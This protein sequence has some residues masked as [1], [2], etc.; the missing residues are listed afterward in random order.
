MAASP[1]VAIVCDFLEENW[2]S[3]DLVANMLF[4][5]LT[6][7]H[8]HEFAFECIRPSFKRRFMRVPRMRNRRGAYNA[9][10]VLNRFFDY[11]RVIRRR[12]IDFDLFHVVDHSYAH[13]VQNV[14]Q[15]KAV[16][17]CHDLD[18]FSPLLNPVY[19]PRAWL[20]AAMARRIVS[21]LRMAAI[22]A[23]VS[24]AT[25]DDLLR[26]GIL[27]PERLTIVPNGT[28][29]DFSPCPNP[30]AN[31][32][33][34]LLL[35]PKIADAPELLHVG[36]SVARKRIDILLHVF[37]AFRH[38]FPRARLIRVGGEPS[39]NH[40]KLAAEL[41][42]RESITFL[43]FIQSAVLAAVYRRVLALV[44]TSEAEGFCLPIAEAMA[45]GTPAIASDLPALREVGG[46]AVCYVPRADVS[47]YVAALETISRQGLGWPRSATCAAGLKQAARFSWT[48]HATSMCAIYRQLL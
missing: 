10:R 26:G 44:I 42:I 21:G 33:A 24:G 13:L 41:G 20:M 17:T 23:C 27:M 37:A 3:M 6:N 38:R 7:G 25:R 28:H 48:D 29:P 34:N 15:G 18:A 46:E 39:A 32:E 45:C 2:P 19:T 9:D 8:S 40:E 11:P 22:V 16:V 31:N 12:L 35:G 4:Q 1:R 47:G 30:S 36:S 14:P 5:A 43:P